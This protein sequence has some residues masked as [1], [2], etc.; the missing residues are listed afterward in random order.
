M[1]ERKNWEQI[2]KKNFH[3]VHRIC[4]CRRGVRKA[5]VPDDSTNRTQ[6]KEG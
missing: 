6:T 3:C 2:R 4:V 5:W 1:D